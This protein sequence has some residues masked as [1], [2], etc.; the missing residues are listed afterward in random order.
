MLSWLPG[1]RETD[2]PWAPHWYAAV[3]VSTGFGPPE[4]DVVDLPAEAQRVA[5]RCL[6]YY[7]RLAKFRIS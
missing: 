6:P 3:E 4:T 2:G 1:R 7:D 5:D